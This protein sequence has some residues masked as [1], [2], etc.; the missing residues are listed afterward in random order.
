MNNKV[1]IVDRNGN[2][3]IAEGISYIT[4]KG[5]GFSNDYLLYTL[6]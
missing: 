1:Y 5:D 2:Q 4:L 3:I 6:N